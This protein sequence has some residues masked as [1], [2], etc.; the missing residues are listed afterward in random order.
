[1]KKFMPQHVG[2]KH[3]CFTLIELLVV[4]AII[5][6]LAAILLPA[7]NSAR[8]RGRSASCINNLKQ[9]SNAVIFYADA[10]DDYLVH[11]SW[12]SNNTWHREL[13]KIIVGG[14]GYTGGGVFQCPSCPYLNKKGEVPARSYAY[15]QTCY[16]SGYDSTHARFG[17]YR[18]LGNIANPSLRPLMIDYYWYN[19]TGSSEPTVQLSYGLFKTKNDPEYKQ[20]NWHN[21]KANILAVDGHVYSDE[22]ILA[23]YPVHRVELNYRFPE[24]CCGSKN[25]QPHQW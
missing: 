23:N 17:N 1:M 11:C 18:K 16:L 14:K 6:I 24:A 7:L 12:D 3:S 5:A 10:N 21:N 2:V 22:A 25:D 8:E 13:E 19:Y 20:T 15:N 9:F 4:I